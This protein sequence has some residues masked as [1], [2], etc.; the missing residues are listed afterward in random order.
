VRAEVPGVAVA[1]RLNATDGVPYPYGFGV[2]PDVR[3]A[4][5]PT[6][7]RRLARMLADAGCA[8]LN[9]TAGIPT[10][11]PHIG[12][13]FDRPAAGMLP[14]PEHPLAGVARLLGLAAAIQSAVPGAP[15]VATG[16]SWLRQFWPPVAAGVLARG[17]AGFAGLGRGAFAYPDAPADLMARGALDQTKCCIAC[18]RCTE[19]M[20]LGSTAGCAVR[21]HPLYSS[22]HRDAVAAARSVT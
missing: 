3:G 19:L 11:V 6:E 12:R 1:V 13:P 4:V 22:L 16:L 7:P 18:S 10:F 14:P 8:L 21:D 9:V 2:S 20:R 15:V 5:D 17:M